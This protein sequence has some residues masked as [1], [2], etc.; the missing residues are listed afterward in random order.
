MNETY[1]PI[2]EQIFT[3]NG[4]KYSVKRLIELTKLKESIE[5]PMES[6]LHEL[7][8]KSWS[9]EI[10]DPERRFPNFSAMDVYEHMISTKNEGRKSEE[11]DQKYYNHFRR[12]QTANPEFPI[13]LF[14][15]K[16]GVEMLADG[17]HRLLHQY[18]AKSPSIKAV[19]FTYEEMQEARI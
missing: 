5:V 14:T 10:H 1:K 6:L 13:I 2:K 16:D 15:N 4:E 17:L 9:D 18:V 7:E 19:R 8:S 11:A 12:T 3:T